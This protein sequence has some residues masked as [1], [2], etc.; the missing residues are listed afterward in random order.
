[1]TDQQI[2]QCALAYK[3]LRER[4]SY[5][6]K[7]TQ[8]I[9]VDHLSN[10]A[11]ILDVLGRCVAHGES[12]MAAS[13]IEING[14]IDLTWL[15]QHPKLISAKQTTYAIMSKQLITALLVTNSEY[16]TLPEQVS[17][18]IYLIRKIIFGII[19]LPK[20]LYDSIEFPNRCLTCDKI[21]VIRCGACK[22]AFYCS[23]ACLRKDIKKHKPDC[24]QV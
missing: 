15:I 8:T 11:Y 22:R 21:C 23:R 7:D 18:K 2:R 10:T 9:I 16:F 13:V 24:A 6:T 17:G 1:M 5:I 4:I 12:L 3:V 20:S 19:P 14:K